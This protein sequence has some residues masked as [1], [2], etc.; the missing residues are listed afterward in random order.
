MGG[1]FSSDEA[2]FGYFL[3]LQKVTEKPLFRTAKQSPIPPHYF[4]AKPPLT[5]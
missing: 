1:C 3:L 2:V 5:N 4:S